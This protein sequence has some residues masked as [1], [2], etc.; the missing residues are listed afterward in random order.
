[1]RRPAPT[2]WNDGKGNGIRVGEGNPNNPQIYQQVDHVVINSGGEITGRN[3]KPI[4]SSIDPSGILGSRISKHFRIERNYPNP[5]YFDDFT[6]R[7]NVL[8]DTTVLD[9]PNA[10]VGRT[11]ASTR[12][13]E[14]MQVLADRLNEILDAVSARSPDSGFLASPLW[15]GIVD[16]SISALHVM[17]Q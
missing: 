2:R 6:L 17:T 3:G 1:M 11:P 13:A 15:D 12:E 16:A 5:E 8:D 14:A 10:A 7:V 9:D 4:P